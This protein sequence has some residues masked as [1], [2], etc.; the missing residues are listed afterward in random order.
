M[1]GVGVRDLNHDAEI[2]ES[3]QSVVCAALVEKV[4]GGLKGG[5]RSAARAMVV[6]GG[7]MAE[8]LETSRA[9]ASASLLLS[10]Q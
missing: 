9:S 10:L 6:S 3:V 4:E 8:V 7:V 5:F 1:T 2:P